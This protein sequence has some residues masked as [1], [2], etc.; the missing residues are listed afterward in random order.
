MSLFLPGHLHPSTA[1]PTHQWPFPKRQGA[2]YPAR[3]TGAISWHQF[4][5]C[6]SSEYF[7]QKGQWTCFTL[8]YD[9]LWKLTTAFILSW[10]RIYLIGQ[11][12]HKQFS[13]V[14]LIKTVW[15]IF[16]LQSKMCFKYF[17]CPNEHF[18][19]GTNKPFTFPPPK[20]D[21]FDDFVVKFA[22]KCVIQWPLSWSFFA[23]KHLKP[24]FL[25]QSTLFLVFFS[26][27]PRR[28][29]TRLFALC[30][31]LISHS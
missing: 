29:S 25:G 23:E 1:P 6:F 31:L 21:F 16:F 5:Y 15:K 3:V 30:M 24:P 2:I 17:F 8:G 11:L 10:F 4:G 27:S 13:P 9:D 19:A 14:S 28:L 12:A 26:F 7:S 18:N 22:R 20:R